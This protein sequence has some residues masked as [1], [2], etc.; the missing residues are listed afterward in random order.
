MREHVV[1]RRRRVG[2]RRARPTVAR[3]RVRAREQAAEVDQPGR[4]A[5]QQGQV[6][7]VVE[8]DLGA[9]DRAQ[10]QR[11]CADGE[12]HRARDRVVI[13]EGQ[14]LV[15]QPQRGRHQLIGQRCPV[16]ERERRMAVQ[17][18]IHRTYVRTWRRRTRRRRDRPP[19][20]PRRY[21]PMS[22]GVVMWDFDGTLATR[23]G[24]WGACVLEVLDEQAP[25]HAGTLAGSAPTPRRL[26][27]APGRRR[28]PRA[29]GA[30]A[31][32][33]SLSP[34]LGRAF[35]GAGIDAAATARWSTPSAPGSSTAPAA[36]GCSTTPAGP[37][38]HRRRRLAQRDP[39]QPCARAARPGGDART[40]R[41]GRR[42]VQ[43]GTIGYEKPHP[44]AFRHALSGMR[45]P[46][47]RLDDRRQP[48]GRRPGA[49]ALGIP[50]VL[51][52]TPGGEPDALA[53]AA[54]VTAP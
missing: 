4:V 2:G 17:L 41:P 34:L 36:G 26:S 22:Q 44:E 15:P 42:G 11:P 31:W 33:N 45:R 38:A 27:L 8:I 5:D 30:D 48:G 16:Q 51:I 23:P 43:L 53:A 18:R 29:V 50:A 1:Q 49:E 28:P 10:A 39:L 24:L 13:R 9:M 19:T 54:L 40:R 52:R 20:E 7:P 35:T 12:L 47:R 32:W 6:A 25:G 21:W 3:V 37:A 46:P 14:R